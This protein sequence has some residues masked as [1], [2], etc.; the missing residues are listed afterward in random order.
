MAP[1]HDG[2]FVAV[3]LVALAIV[4]VAAGGCSSQPRSP[5]DVLVFA[6]SSLQT[7]IDAI[8]PDITASTGVRLK[9]SYAA[10][11]ALARQIEAGARADLFISADEEW[12]DYVQT[13]GLMK[14]GSRIP[15]VGNR[16]V[17]IA[18]SGGHAP[19]VA[20]RPGVDLVA[21]L[22]GGRLGVADP[23]AVPAGRYARAAL[24][25]LGVWSTV[26]DRLAAAEN[27]RAALLL[28]ARG[29]APLGIV[30]FTDALADRRVTIVD[31]FPAETHP[32]I[33]YPAALTVGASADADRVLAYLRSP[34]A[35]AVFAAQGFTG[36]PRE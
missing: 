32:P 15:I 18:P 33:F 8:A 23:A 22:A 12:M 27:V 14:A 7:A 17:L 1:S 9:T 19:R 2:R 13:R 30:Y 28:V 34:E 21:A 11:S 29:E 31:T 10:S 6:A 24:E 4:V 20:L 5:G 16:L 26:A 35:K 3:I 25:A 36:V